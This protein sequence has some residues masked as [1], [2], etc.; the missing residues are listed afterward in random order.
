MVI[1]GSNDRSLK[2]LERSDPHNLVDYIKESD[3]SMVELTND[4]YQELQV[5]E[6]QTKQD[7][8]SASFNIRQS[9][10]DVSQ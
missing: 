3:E 5:E 1:S 4:V 7:T 6:F 8:S 10:Y 9:S 2:S